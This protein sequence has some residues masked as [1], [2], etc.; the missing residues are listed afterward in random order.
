MC[1][2]AIAP[3]R[4]PSTSWTRLF[5]SSASFF[6]LGLV[7]S[8]PVPYANRL[9]H[10]LTSDPAPHLSHSIVPGRS[11]GCPLS[12]IF[13]TVPSCIHSSFPH[14][15]LERLLGI[16]YLP[17]HCPASDHVYWFYPTRVS[18]TPPSPAQ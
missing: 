4:P 7:S 3:R 14:V 17:S 6:R 13:I 15:H 10:S 5:A 11:Q 8:R 18:F 16:G 9:V 1:I 2:D 12:S